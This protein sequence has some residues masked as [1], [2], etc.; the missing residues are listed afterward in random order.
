MSDLQTVS[1]KVAWLRVLTLA[2]AAFIFNTTEYIPVGLLSDI[3]LSFGME[4]AQAGVMLTIYAWIVA[5]M[6][7]PLMLMTSKIDR[8]VLLLSLFSLF[9]GS[10]LLSFF[11]WNFDVLLVS[12]AGVALAHALFWSITASLAIRLAPAGKRAQALGLLATAT[13][14]AS[15]LGLPLGRIIGQSFGWRVTFLVIGV[16]AMILLAMIIKIMPRV[17]S[18]QSGSLKSLPGLLT[19][20]ALL[21]LYALAVIVVTA[22]F[23][24]FTYIEPFVQ[25]VAGMSHNFA[26]LL[27]LIFGVAGISG[28]II[29]SKYGEKHL[30][31]LLIGAIALLTLCLMTMVSVAHSMSGLIAICA[32][33]GIAFMIIGMGMQMKVLTLAPEATDIGMAMFSGIFNIGIGLGAL[34]GQTVS[35]DLSLSSVGYVGALFGLSAMLIA[36]VAFKK[37]P[38]RA[39]QQEQDLVA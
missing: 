34:V 37:W 9:A 14:L 26:T 22:H 7:L 12:R 2:V 20:P 33:W 30:S 35:I 18:E 28:S 29:F 27:L 24:A 10:H 21:S 3:G 32:L 5:L 1:R 36:I 11:A 16:A 39:R 31:N 23:S 6:S 15:V 8:R 4:S 17:T 38:G 25:Q 19:N 13:A